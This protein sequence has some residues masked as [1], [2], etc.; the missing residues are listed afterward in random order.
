[1]SGYYFANVVMFEAAASLHDTLR[2]QVEQCR[3]ELSV[4]EEIGQ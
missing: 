3:V 1:M 2:S 4:G